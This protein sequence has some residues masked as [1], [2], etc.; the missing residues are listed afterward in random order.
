MPEKRRSTVQRTTGETSIE[1]AVCLDGTGEADLATGVGFLD[2]MLELFARH[3]RFDLT[4][5]AEGDLEVDS[6]HTT[7]DIGIVMGQAFG[8]ALGDKKGITRF[9]DVQ[10]PMQESLAA[11]AVDVCGRSYLLCEA[12]FPTHRVGEF[13]LELVEEFLQ[14]F[15]ANAALTL[16]VQLLRCGNS[17]HGA[18]AI[19]KALA[20]ALRTAVSLDPGAASEI[21]STKGT[22]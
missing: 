1:I 14:A 17:H 5:R 20:R 18:E 4:V 19:F 10:L 16:H 13:D 2:H 3:G 11:V 21:P 15:T 22:L 9:A 7:E 8:Q 6:H 12:D